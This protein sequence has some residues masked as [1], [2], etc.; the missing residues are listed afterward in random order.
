MFW[1]NSIHLSDLNYLKLLVCSKLTDC[2]SNHITRLATFFTNPYGVNASF[3]TLKCCLCYTYCSHGHNRTHSSGNN[4]PKDWSRSGPVHKQMSE[5]LLY[6]PTIIVFLHNGYKSEL[7]CIFYFFNSI[8]NYQFNTL[9]VTGLLSG[10]Q[11]RWL[12]QFI[13]EPC[14][15]T[16]FSH[17]A[18]LFLYSQLGQHKT[19]SSFNDSRYW[20]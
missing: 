10:F 2:I 8:W 12:Q 13:M 6:M 4:A 5:C 20:F 14:R 1:K 18:A 15:C 9:K 3:F 7:Q 11:V 19:F 17:P 16:T